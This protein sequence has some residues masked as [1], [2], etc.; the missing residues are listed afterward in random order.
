MKKKQK[1]DL[2]EQSYLSEFTG[3]SDDS[4]SFIALFVNF[5]HIIPQIDQ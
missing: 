3:T 4:K 1:C 5:T 2:P